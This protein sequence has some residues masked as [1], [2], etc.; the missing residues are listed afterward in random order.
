[1]FAP[2]IV[3]METARAE[4]TTRKIIAKIRTVPLYFELFDFFMGAI[5]P[6]PNKGPHVMSF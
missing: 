5:F 4:N 2:D 6:P 1:M 3:A